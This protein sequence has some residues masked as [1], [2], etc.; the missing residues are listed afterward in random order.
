MVL[1]LAIAML[2]HFLHTVSEPHKQLSLH[3]VTCV[4][5]VKT[6]RQHGMPKAGTHRVRTLEQATED[7]RT[8]TEAGSCGMTPSLMSS[9]A[10]STSSESAAPPANT[11]ASVHT[12]S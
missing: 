8:W 2:K 1:S 5:H 6:S 7:L 10:S 12:H 9:R 3:K 11:G 4:N